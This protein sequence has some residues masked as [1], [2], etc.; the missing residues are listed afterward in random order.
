MGSKASSLNYQ[1]SYVVCIDD[2][3]G[4]LEGA[5]FT[6]VVICSGDPFEVT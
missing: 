5:N 1:L 3:L 6:D 2:K 4:S